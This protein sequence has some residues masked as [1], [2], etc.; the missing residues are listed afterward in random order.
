MHFRRSAIQCL[1]QE[2][3]LQEIS[4]TMPKT[5]QALQEVSDTMPRTRESKMPGKYIHN[6]YH[7]HHQLMTLTT[8]C[9]TAAIHQL[10]NC[11]NHITACN[12][13][14]Q[15]ITTLCCNHGH[16]KKLCNHGDHERTI[17]TKVI[18]H[19]LATMVNM[20]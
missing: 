11:G 20:T 17:L 12:H 9:N 14:D 15:K 1:E 5:R 18:K 8:A 6:Q 7:H 13:C 16:H 2:I 4:D 19:N 10:C 3:A